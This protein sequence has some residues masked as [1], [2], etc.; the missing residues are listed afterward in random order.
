[1]PVGVGRRGVDWG[2]GA[3]QTGVDAPWHIHDGG[4]LKDDA[5][6]D[7]TVLDR[8]VVIDRR[9]WPDIG[10]AYDGPLAND[11]GAA[12]HAIGNACPSFNAHIALQHAIGRDD[13][14]WVDRAAN[15]GQHLTVGGQNIFHLS[16]VDP[17]VLQ[18]VWTDSVAMIDEPLNCVGDLKL[19]TS[20][21]LDAL[22][23]LDDVPVE[24]I[25]ADQ[26]EI[27]RRHLRL[28]DQPAY[29]PLRFPPPG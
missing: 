2:E 27:A 25:D 6:F 9:E 24:A 15:T 17:K 8:H 11:R 13:G 10:V 3:D 29:P 12:H 23:G 4:V 5:I 20:R 1:M 7:L 28:L 26:R 18:E 19:A 16:S 14:R 21:R 22:S